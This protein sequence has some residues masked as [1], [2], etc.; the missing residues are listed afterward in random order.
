MTAWAFVIGINEYP[1]QSK[2]PRL[3]GAVADAADFA[4]WAIDPN[5]G[6]VSPG[7][8]FFW[9]CPAPNAPL[10]V[11]DAFLASPTR[12][13]FVGPDFDRP[14]QAPEIKRA[15]A[16]VARQ[17]VAAG[18]QRLYVFFAGHG[19]QT[20]AQ[21]YEE[22]PQN[23]F[24]AGDF[25]SDMPSLGLVGCDDLRRFLQ[26]QGPP[27][28]VMFL[29]CCRNALPRK[30]PK[31]SSNFDL[32]GTNGLHRRLAIGR[33][34]QDE[35]MAYEVPIGEAQPK[36]GAFSKLLINALRE[37]RVGGRLTLRD[38]DDYVTNGI[39]DLVKPNLQV[40]DFV[41]RP[42]PPALVLTIGPPLGAEPEV[43]VRF[44]NVAPGTAV[45]IHD[46][47]AALVL[48]VIASDESQRIPLPIS[49]Y[50]LELADGTVL[51]AFNHLG[52]GTTDVVI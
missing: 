11:L 12:W 20:K 4:D 24:I 47:N 38:L 51:R 23:C 41:E 26:S 35:A 19:A 8:L 52:P 30:V 34:S 14:P 27:E 37:F 21:T 25:V 33:A 39:V 49:G 50:S 13:P 7:H 40:P 32:L 43:H 29:D 10:P 16:E 5:G 44:E 2:Q 45:E 22:D 42:K 15:V 36:R 9:T 48:T 31:P 3:H 1:A 18:A 6:A 28:I 17:A 46:K